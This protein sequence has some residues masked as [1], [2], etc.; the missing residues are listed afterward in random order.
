[1]T[2]QF[3]PDLKLK[4][5]NY[6]LCMDDETLMNETGSTTPQRYRF[7]IIQTLEKFWD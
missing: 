4:A 3:T 6:Y 1:M 2:K 5:V 7:N